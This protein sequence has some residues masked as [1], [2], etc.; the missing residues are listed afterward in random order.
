MSKAVNGYTEA[1]GA[2]AAG[3]L[4]AAVNDRYASQRAPTSASVVHTIEPEP[5]IEI[6][7]Q[8]KQADLR[9]RYKCEGRSAGSL[10]GEHSNDSNKTYPTI[11]VSTSQYGYHRAGYHRD[12]ITFIYITLRIYVWRCSCRLT[13]HH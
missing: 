12:G 3:G 10:L 9:F 4:Y 6:V 1:A 7:E 2:A 13:R 5:W 11:R 8:P